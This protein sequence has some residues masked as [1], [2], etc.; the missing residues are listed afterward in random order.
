[1]C[2]ISLVLIYIL[3]TSYSCVSTS[4]CFYPLLPLFIIIKQLLYIYGCFS[5]NIILCIIRVLL[6]TIEVSLSSYVSFYR[7]MN[8]LLCYNDFSLN[9]IV[10]LLYNDQKLYVRIGCL[11]IFQTFACLTMSYRSLP[12][13][14][15]VTLFILFSSHSYSLYVYYYYYFNVIS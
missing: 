8:S 12:A 4:L 1:M 11:S 13:V 9:K 6:P 15:D 14:L 2:I 10:I 7:T 5:F 3:L